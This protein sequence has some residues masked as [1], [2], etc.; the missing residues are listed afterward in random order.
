MPADSI[1]RSLACVFYYDEEAAQWRQLPTQ[2]STDGAMW[3]LSAE[4]GAPGVY[5]AALSS[6][7][8]YGNYK[9]PW[10]PT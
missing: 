6:E 7:P 5:T 1:S 4:A 8:E 2:R 10:Q 3:Q 9:Q